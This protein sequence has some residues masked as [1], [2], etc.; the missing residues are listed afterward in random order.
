MR[1]PTDWAV[2]WI[3]GRLASGALT[4]EPMEVAGASDGITS[5]SGEVKLTTSSPTVML[6]RLTE[7]STRAG[8]PYTIT[9]DVR[10]ARQ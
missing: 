8:D 5:Y 10:T 7:R 9:W 3:S 4:F 6:G 2:F 1:D